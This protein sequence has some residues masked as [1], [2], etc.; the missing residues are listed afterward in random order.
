LK[1][2]SVEEHH[3]TSAARLGCCQAQALDCSPTP[4]RIR[5]C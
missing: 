3:L 1:Y 2:R 5:A 4:I